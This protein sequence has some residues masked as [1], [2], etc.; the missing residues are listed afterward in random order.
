MVY[1]E[2]MSAV[3]NVVDGRSGLAPQ[4]KKRRR[5]QK[6]ASIVSKRTSTSSSERPGR[7]RKRFDPSKR[8]MSASDVKNVPKIVG[9]NIDILYYIT[10]PEA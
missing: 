5:G 4:R 10:T 1:N 2:R 7:L 9:Q 3:P 8:R 6:F